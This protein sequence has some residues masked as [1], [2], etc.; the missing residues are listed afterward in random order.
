MGRI[1][2]RL[3]YHDDGFCFRD[4]SEYVVDPRDLVLHR[5]RPPGFVPAGEPIV[6]R[7]DEVEF[8]HVPSELELAAAFPNRAQRLKGQP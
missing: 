2:T 1:R 5:G 8:D 7:D 4:A 6:K 3:L